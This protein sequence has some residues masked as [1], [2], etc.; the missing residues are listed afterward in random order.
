MNGMS[1]IVAHSFPSANTHS[2]QQQTCHHL[3]KRSF[4]AFCLC[5]EPTQWRWL[6]AGAGIPLPLSLLLPRVCG[7]GPSDVEWVLTAAK[8]MI[9]TRE[10]PKVVVVV[11]ESR[12][13][14]CCG[15]QTLK[16]RKKHKRRAVQKKAEGQSHGGG[17]AE[18]WPWKLTS[19]G[20]PPSQTVL[21][22][23]VCLDV[24][25]NQKSSSSEHSYSKWNIQSLWPAGSTT[26]TTPPKSHS[27]SLD[28]W[29][30]SHKARH[31]V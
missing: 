24:C 28:Q 6:W 10:R 11:V 9:K 23:K 25:R 31:H 15:R 14:S 8:A 27:G 5:A 29:S 4:V 19:E 3:K 7:G 30:N 26:G 12:R 18:A 22:R 2:R 21:K 13:C 16:K 1:L 20:R 17:L